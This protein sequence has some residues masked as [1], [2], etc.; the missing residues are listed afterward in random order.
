MKMIYRLMIGTMIFGIAGLTV[1]MAEST[2]RHYYQKHAEFDDMKNTG[3]Q[4]VV[5]VND[6]E[7]EE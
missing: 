1:G 4:E 2:F 6:V 5:L 3:V 7:V